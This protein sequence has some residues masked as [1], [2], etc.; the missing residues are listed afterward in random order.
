MEEILNEWTPFL[1]SIGSVITGWRI[2]LVYEARE[3]WIF[4]DT[5]MVMFFAAALVTLIGMD[6][7][8]DV[9]A[10]PRDLLARGIG[11]AF[12]AAGIAGV[13]AA[14]ALVMD[15]YKRRPRQTRTADTEPQQGPEEPLSRE[16]A[17]PDDPL[18][19]DPGRF[20]GEAGKKRGRKR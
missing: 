4:P 19:L 9:I 3:R 16:H 14:F 20:T 12:D 7:R 5:L 15:G 6:V 8:Q 18:G 2:S 13:P 17:K 1:V 11:L 10:T